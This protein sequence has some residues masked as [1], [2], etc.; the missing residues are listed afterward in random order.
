MK[1]SSTGATKFAICAALMCLSVQ[2]SADGIC[3][4][5]TIKNI[6]V[7]TY[8][9]GLCASGNC[10]FIAVNGSLGSYRP[11]CATN[12]S[13]SFVLDMSTQSGRSTYAFLL[14]A[15]ATAAAV[16]VYGSNNC[17]LSPSG[18]TETLTAVTFAG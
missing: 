18:A 16:N 8:Y 17:N 10:A 3:N 12:T 1:T 6:G 2:A 7:G 4:N 15:K 9:D 5:C 13:W 11:G 14:S